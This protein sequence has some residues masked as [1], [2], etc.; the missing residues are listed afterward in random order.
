LEEVVVKKFLRSILRF[1]GFFFALMDKIADHLSV[2]PKKELPALTNAG[3][4]I[5]R[6]EEILF[7]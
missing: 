6:R 3:P 1:L 5:E 4:L 2:M 7:K